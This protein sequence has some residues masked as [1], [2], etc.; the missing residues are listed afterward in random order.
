[1]YRCKPLFCLAV[2]AMA[3]LPAWPETLATGRDVAPAFTYFTLDNGLQVLLQEKHDLPVSGITLAVD[4]GIKDETEPNSG[5][6]HL[7][8]HLLLFGSSAETSGAARLAEFRSHGIAANAHTDSD[9]MTFEV[10]CPAAD[11]AWVLDGLRESVFNHRL[12]EQH[13]E[14]EKRIIL[15]EILQMR[16][17]P[18]FL[19]RL[20]IMQQLFPGHPYG[21]SPLG[22]PDAIGR[23]TVGELRAF[24]KPYLVPNR[25][26]LSVIGDFDLIVMEKLVRESWGPLAKNDSKATAI[27]AAGRLEKN[28][29]QRLEMDLN[30]SHLFLGWWA[31]DTNHEHR[32]G[33]SLLTY[34]LGRGLNPLF[35]AVLGGTRRLVDQLDMSYAPMAHGGMVVL[36]MILQEKDIPSVRN[37]VA[38]FL[39]QV[40]SFKFAKEDYPAVQQ[41]YVVD[42][43]QSAKNQMTYDSGSFAESA[44]NLSL[45][46][47][48]FLLLNRNPIAGS[49]LENVE[50]LGSSDLRRVAARY[51]SGKKMASLAI[52]PLRKGTP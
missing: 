5:Y 46:S 6:T 12:D 50:K 13:L 51:L 30:E 17:N 43:L 15:E 52:V 35:Y 11:S 41:P 44:L 23:A 26:A 7:L 18:N 16:D 42:Y 19:G 34:V 8:E 1:M 33:M 45:A 48:R 25:C 22:D 3:F 2:I 9:L 47:A 31:P 28:V 4:L 37:E 39:S 20:L 49:Y 24:A 10:S 27:P 38:R 40:P 14:K 36:H 29:E 32:M 21:R